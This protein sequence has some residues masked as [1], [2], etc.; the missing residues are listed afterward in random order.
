MG[1][2]GFTGDGVYTGPAFLE[3]LPLT[4]ALDGLMNDPGL[5]TKQKQAAEQVLEVFVKW[6]QDQMVKKKIRI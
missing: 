1:A 5:T 2:A 3:K 6:L 4:K